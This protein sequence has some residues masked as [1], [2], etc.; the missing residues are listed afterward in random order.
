MEMDPPVGDEPSLA[1]AYRLYDHD[2]LNEFVDVAKALLHIDVNRYQR[3]KIFIPL[4][5]CAETDVET[6]LYYMQAQEKFD[7]AST[8]SD[9]SDQDVRLALNEL[10]SDFAELLKTVREEE[11]NAAYGPG[12][13][14][15]PPPG[16]PPPQRTT[17]PYDPWDV[18]PTQINL[19]PQAS[20]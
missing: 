20:P 6:S 1:T 13:S 19:E 17:G 5:N 11:A 16:A 9:P 15:P 3:I 8:F 18:A 2:Q 10:S 14:V 12:D 7:Y 4:A